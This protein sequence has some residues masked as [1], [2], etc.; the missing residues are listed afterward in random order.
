MRFCL[1]GESGWVEMTEKCDF[2]GRRMFPSEIRH[3]LHGPDAQK[4]P[5][6]LYQ[7]VHPEV[8]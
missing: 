1:T 6:K 8:T 7:A 5:K 4:Q 2:P 3:L